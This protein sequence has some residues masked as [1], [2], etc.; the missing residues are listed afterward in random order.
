M[1]LLRLIWG[2][3]TPVILLAALVALGAWLARDS[4]AKQATLE[5]R[6]E[7][8]I[9][10]TIPAQLSDFEV[11]VETVGKLEAVNSKPIMT[12]VSGQILRIIPNGLKVKKDDVIAE[13]DVPRMVRQLQ[14]QDT[15]YQDALVQLENK[16]RGL[17]ADV[18]RSQIVFDQAQEDWDQ[19]KVKQQAALEEQRRQSEYD[20][21]KLERDK[22]RY[23]R[24]SK[25]AGES[26]I[27]KQTIEQEG[28]GLKAQEFGLERQR[29]DL[30]L[31]EAKKSAEALDKQATFNKAKMDL[32]RAKSAQESGVSGAQMQL[33]INRKQLQ[34]LQDQLAKAV[35][36]APVD[37]IIVLE[38]QHREGART[39]LQA[40]DRVWEGRKVAS[41]PD[42]S[43]MQASLELT[44]DQMR[45]IKK[46]LKAQVVVDAVGGKAF[47]AEVS[48]VAQ[49]AKE[50]EGGIGLSTGN[51]TFHCVVAL[52][53]LK[54]ADLRPGMSCNIKIIVERIPKVLSL[55][56]ECIFDRDGKKVIYVKRS[57]KFKMVEVTLGEQ[58]AD[59]VVIK[60]GLKPGDWVAL[61]EV[62]EGGNPTTD[63][64]EKSGA[65]PL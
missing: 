57:G 31:E 4:M 38:E 6:A 19:F 60:R 47:E 44:Q 9:V 11:T 39:T 54:G 50:A 45:I 5:R 65:L 20:Q 62:D 3:L 34:R 41:I 26:L 58:N 27:P 18:E 51:R 40:G 21:Q 23:G 37:G 35:I 36:R 52:K 7:E 56:L 43:K 33:E 24:R 64:K 25:L 17:Q 16:K 29:K 48:E 53:E 59:Q 2:G 12:D 55:P 14:D 1:K 28:F 46:K 61:R 30:Q 49:N 13:L 63:S 10:A 8:Q 42:L 32:M 22:A 15:Q